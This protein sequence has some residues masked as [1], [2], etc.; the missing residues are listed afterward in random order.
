MNL[1]SIA[2]VFYRKPSFLN[3]LK[4]IDQLDIGEGSIVVDYGSGAGFWTLPLS[5]KV[6]KKGVVYSLSSNEGFISL[7]N[8]KASLEGIRNIETKFVGLEKKISLD[9]KA[10]I[11]VISNILHLVKDRDAVLKNAK[12]FLKKDGRILLVDFV[13]LRSVFGPPLENRLSEE[14]VMIMADK[15]GLHFKCIIDAGWYHYGLIFD[16]KN[17]VGGKN[18][19]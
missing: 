19:R 2:N 11:V 3:P 17:Y 18:V 12:S 8:K 1:K 6:G 4:V 5:K 10:D 14:D 7:I 9:Q 13:K 15:L 16:L